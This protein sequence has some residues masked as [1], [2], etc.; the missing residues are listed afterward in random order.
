MASSLPILFI[1]LTLFLIIG[2]LLKKFLQKK[3]KM[4]AENIYKLINELEKKYIH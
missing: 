2:F 4:S 3:R 1:E